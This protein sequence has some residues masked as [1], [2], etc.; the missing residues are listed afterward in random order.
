MHCCVST[1]AVLMR[2]DVT[3]Y[4]LCLCY[5]FIPFFVSG[6]SGLKVLKEEALILQGILRGFLYIV[7][8]LIMTP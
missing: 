1:A 6:N 2:I 4:V 5:L 3:V 7:I 8:N